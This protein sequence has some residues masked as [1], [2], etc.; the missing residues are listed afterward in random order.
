V[1]TDLHIPPTG[2]ARSRK[3][4]ADVLHAATT[5]RRIARAVARN[6]ARFAFCLALLAGMA[7][8]VFTPPLR[9]A[10]ERDQFT[11]AYQISSGTITTVHR[12]NYYGALLPS[13]YQTDMHDLTVATY[14]DKDQTAFLRSLSEPPPTGHR[15]FVEDGTFATYGPGAYVVY[16]AAIAVGRAIGLGIVELIYL[17]RFA[18]VL[19]YALLFAL[20]VRR[21]PIH[22][23]VLVACGLIPE[24]VNQASTVSADGMTMVLAFLVVAEAL[25]L[26][27]DRRARTPRVLVEV[28]LAS[29]LLALAK[30]PYMLFVLLLVIPAWR[31]RRRLL[32]PLGA[33]CAVSAVLA[34]LWLSYEDHHSMRQDLPGFWLGF[35]NKYSYAFRDIHIKGQLHFIES[36]PVNFL[37][38]V[39]NTFAYKGLAFPDQMFGLMAT[40]QLPVTLVVLSAVIVVAAW[41][42]PDAGAA[43][44]LPRLDRT[45]LLVVTTVIGLGVCAL[46]YAGANAYRAPRIDQLTPR[47]MLPLLPAWMVGLAPTR[48]RGSKVPAL[49]VAGGLVVLWALT[50]ASLQHFQFAT[51]PLY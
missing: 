19:A 45:V 47:Y 31:F 22:R 25:A 16:A 40:F 17:A 32:V 23:W 13:G 46:I 33:V 50:I 14:N 35:P 10:D 51:H 27:L 26:A 49:A 8:A 24:A 6:P 29:A 30:P 15:V 44:T 42:V 4:S 2:G 18:G 3:G 21:L 37:H 43:R 36:N 7:I 41:F 11:R 48:W 5:G 28:A 20:A 1:T 38:V 9:G 12:G 39:L 34:G